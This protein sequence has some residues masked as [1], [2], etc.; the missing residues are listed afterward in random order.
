M[1]SCTAESQLGRVPRPPRDRPS[2]C[3]YRLTFSPLRILQPAWTQALREE[4]QL[5]VQELAPAP[6]SLD[7]VAAGSP[8]RWHRLVLALHHHRFDARISPSPHSHREPS[9]ASNAKAH[10]SS[11]AT[12]DQLELARIP[13]A[14]E[15]P[16]SRGCHSP[17]AVFLFTREDSE[18]EA[19]SSPCTAGCAAT[20]DEIGSGHHHPAGRRSGTTWQHRVSWA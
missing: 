16:S 8:Q 1:E 11:H 14:P 10:C 12:L 7:R 5:T 20:G 6:E 19:S 2:E 9:R 3:A 17:S 4:S 18:L 15:S 13:R